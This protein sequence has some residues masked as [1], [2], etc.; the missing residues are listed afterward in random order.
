MAKLPVKLREQ[1]ARLPEHGLIKFG[2]KDEKRKGAPKAVPWMRFCSSD[3]AA[4]AQLAGMYGGDVEPWQNGYG[5]NWWQVLTSTSEIR[6][7]LPRDPLGDG[8]I[9][10]RWKGGGCERRCDGETCTIPRGMSGDPN[11][12]PVD[13]PCL[14]AAEGALSCKPH[15]RLKVMLPGLDPFVGV[16]RLEA[17]GDHA[18]DELPG[19]VGLVL[20]AQGRG[21][22][23]GVLRLEQRSEYGWNDRS[24]KRELHHYVT[25]VVGV[26]ASFDALLAGEA[27][28]RALGPS[29]Q[30]LALNP[31][32]APVTSIPE[33]E[34]QVDDYEDAEIVEDALSDLDARVG[35]RLDGAPSDEPVLEQPASPPPSE[36]EDPDA[37]DEAAIVEDEMR[38]LRQKI[39]MDLG[40]D[41]TRHALA[42]WV[43]K[44]R[45]DSTREL[46]LD[47]LKRLA[48]GARKIRQGRVKVTVIG[49]EAKVERVT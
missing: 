6:I 23:F 29:S 42:R 38:A 25:P 13:C 33:A 12:E 49:G 30:T 7:V 48:D 16:W 36:W 37:R 10:E 21:M 4:I 24:A 45:T 18:K 27:R 43:S 8:P 41:E 3:K 11:P 28:A 2:V 35:E 39:A 32:S 17:K 44:G 34:I 9:Y 47:E 40:S 22:A 14:C 1:Q 5:R 46:H 19:M 26:A 31:S 20:E 15:T